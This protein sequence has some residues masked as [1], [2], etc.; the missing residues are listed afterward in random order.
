MF[1]VAH[2]FYLSVFAKSVGMGFLLG[3]LYCAFMLLRRCG[4]RRTGAVIAED[5]LFFLLCAVFTFLFVFDVNAGKARFYIF[6][7]EGI[8]L[9]SFYLLPGKTVAALAG[10]LFSRVGASLRG[11]RE[12]NRKNKKKKTQKV[13]QEQ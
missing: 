8:G 2:S 5:I 1:G 3:A 4:L 9:F 7:G 13:L 11:F 10:G 6:A 12:K